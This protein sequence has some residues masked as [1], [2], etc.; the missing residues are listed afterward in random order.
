MT[1]QFSSTLRGAFALAMALMLA[2][3]AALWAPQARAAAVE[4]TEAEFRWALNKQSSGP[5]HGPG[6]NFLSAGDISGAITGPDTAIKPSDWKATSGDVTIEKRGSGG[7]S[8]PATWDGVQTDQSG[9]ALSGSSSKYSGLEMVFTGGEGT[10]DAAAGTA[11]IEW[12]GTASVLYYSGFVYLTVSDPVLAV[13]PSRAVVTATLG[14]HRSDRDDAS[15]WTKMSPKTVTLAVLDRDEIDLS[16]ETGFSA[17]PDYR[18]VSYSRADSSMPQVKTGSDWGAFPD[19]FIDFAKESGSGGFWYSTGGS[20]DATKVPFS[21]VVSWDSDDPYSAANPGS[22]GS[23]GSGDSGGSDGIIGEVIG[24]TAEDIIRAAGTD[25]AGTAEAWMDEAWKPLQPDAVKAAQDRTTT[26]SQDADDSSTVVDE[27]FAEQYEEFYT[28]S[29]PM[30]AGTVGA[31]L[32]TITIP[33]A[34]GSAA[35]AAAP[36]P[37]SGSAA[38]PSGA[39]IASNLPLSEVAYAQTSASQETG[40]PIHQWQWWIGFALLALAAGL[41][42]QTVR[43]KD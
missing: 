14:G 23:G 39:P 7:T 16:D 9:T 11:E 40:N 22:G 35:P 43:R 42:Y 8:A 27:G 30:T 38:A 28:V 18:G 4:I 37:A 29:T 5:S 41:F 33:A 19:S 25:V 20:S 36:A 12:D 21:I 24:D 17:E 10:V 34:A 6:L 13:T 3:A 26:P 1:K 31:T 32:A 2:M 15:E